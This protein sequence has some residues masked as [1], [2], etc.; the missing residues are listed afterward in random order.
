MRLPRSLQLL[1]LAVVAVV[2]TVGFPG[3]SSATFTAS[4]QATATVQAAVDWTPP[5][6]SV[7]SPGTAVK[8]TATIAMTATDAETGIASVTLERFAPGASDWAIVCTDTTSPYS[9]AWNTSAVADGQ[10]SLRARATD[11]AGYEST[12]DFV[13][14]TVANNVLVVLA[15]PGD[16]VRGTVPLATSVY[17]A[18]VTHT[19]RVDYAPTGTTGWKTICTGLS[20]PY[21]CSWN[22]SALAPGDYD[23]R[24]VLTAGST[25]TVSALVE[26]VTVD[27]AGPSV[28][29]LDPGSPLSGTPRRPPPP[30]PT[31]VSPGSSSSTC[32]AAPRPGWTCAPSPT[33]RSAA[34]SPPR[35]C[36]T[37]PT[38]SAP[39]P[40]TWRATAP[41]QAR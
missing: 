39:S 12:S 3:F 4:S 11:N 32:A 5:T 20:S 9:C 19:V 38:P 25:T 24:S 33:S 21:A 23:L 41:R 17:N 18:T 15:S 26:A 35:R 31:P 16:V 22:T 28:T 2:L 13:R 7:V 34:A 1:L 8:G 40:P 29:M 14:T 6:V 37:A 36:S 30:T 27:N 10:Y